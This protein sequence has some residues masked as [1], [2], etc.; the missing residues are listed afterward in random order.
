MVSF[1]KNRAALLGIED[2]GMLWV[3]EK[4]VL[5]HGFYACHN[6][7]QIFKDEIDT[8]LKIFFLTSRCTSVTYSERM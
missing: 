4:Y 5:Q 8:H 7:V 1:T 6:P 2:G 3:K